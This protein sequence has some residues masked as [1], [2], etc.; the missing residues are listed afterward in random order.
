MTI[1]SRNGK[2]KAIVFDENVNKPKIGEA[3]SLIKKHYNLTDND[4]LNLKSSN[5]DDIGIKHDR[6]VQYY[7]G[8]MVERSDVIVHSK[9]DFILSINGDAISIKNLNISPSIGTKDAIQYGLGKIN[10]N[11]Y[12]LELPEYESYLNKGL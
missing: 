4:A 12:A 2:S 5:F 6:Y 8:V 3:I 9:N 1:H 7:Q 11:K 10:A